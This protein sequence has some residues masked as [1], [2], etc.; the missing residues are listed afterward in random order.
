MVTIIWRTTLLLGIVGLAAILVGC[1]EVVPEPKKAPIVRPPEPEPTEPEV[2]VLSR[3]QLDNDVLTVTANRLSFAQPVSYEK[4]DFITAEL[5]AKTPY[6]MLREV[7]SVSS[8]R[9][10]VTTSDASLEDVLTEG[11]V[12]ISGTLTPND[13]T[14]AS[15]AALAESV[16]VASGGGSLGPAA[17]GELRFGYDLS[18]TEGGSTLSGRIDFVLAYEL[19]VNYDGGLK[20]MRFSI[21]PQQVVTVTVSA[22]GAFD[23]QWR[24]GRTLRFSAL[25]VPAAPFP[26]YFTP[27]LDLL[28]GVN[29]GWETSV[30][31]RHALSVTA[32]AECKENCSESENW[33][34]IGD[35]SQ[36]QASGVGFS[37]EAE[38]MLRVYVAPQLTFNLYGRVGGPHIAAI[39]SIGARA[40]KVAGKECLRLSLDG[41]LAA[42]LGGAAEVSVLGVTLVS[43]ALD[44]YRFDVLDPV[45]VWEAE[46]GECEDETATPA[47]ELT[48][49]IAFEGGTVWAGRPP[50]PTNNP[51]DPQLSGAPA[52]PST[53]APG[54]EDTMGIGFSNVPADTPFDVNVRFDD[55]NQFINIPI[56]TAITGG[57]SSGTLNLPFSLPASACDNLAAVKHQIEC[58]ESVSVGGVSVSLEQARQLVLDCTVQELQ[59]CLANRPQPSASTFRDCEVCPDMVEVP[60]GSFM[61]GA[62]ETEGYSSYR[63]RPVH[64]VTIDKPFA[65]G[66][67]EVTFAEWDACLADGGCGGYAPDDYRL[68]TLFA[69][70]YQRV[71]G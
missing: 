64:Q 30:R 4:G 43:A 25:P 20:D 57:N 39:P 54:V 55:A 44:E 53:I 32:G 24:V 70:G 56:D 47:E 31:A 16:L 62:P 40:A 34:S 17:A 5:S 41:A 3:S 12:T 45:V 60:V 6:G 13:L 22:K 69:T 18:A 36:S 29:G 38:G 27:E 14:P 11:T 19:T 67:Y 61:M 59:A 26:I 51:G 65:V 33:N 58:Y 63:E 35:V 15:K 49:S 42:T 71:L 52:T 28:A 1:E 48:D 8:D 21:T 9:Q 2:H 68:G 66:V 50:A 23:R 7:T 37:T 46:H 10:T